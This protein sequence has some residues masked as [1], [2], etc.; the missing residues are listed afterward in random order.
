MCPHLIVALPGYSTQQQQECVV[1][2]DTPVLGCHLSI[3]GWSHLI[4]ELLLVDVGHKLTGDG[5]GKG[6]ELKSTFDKLFHLKI[7]FSEKLH[8]RKLH[9]CLCFA[10]NISFQTQAATTAILIL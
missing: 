4:R 8:L 5:E 7:Q 3:P 10:C 1:N 6:E 9:Q 2:P